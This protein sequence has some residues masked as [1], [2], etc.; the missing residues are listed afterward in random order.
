MKVASGFSVIAG[1]IA[2]FHNA[3]Q[4]S[5]LNASGEASLRRQRGSS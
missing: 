3:I 2:A 4:T 5:N 1:V